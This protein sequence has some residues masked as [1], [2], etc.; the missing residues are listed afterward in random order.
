MKNSNLHICRSQRA[1][2]TVSLK[3][4][5]PI[6]PVGRGMYFGLRSSN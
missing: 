3:G 1:V 2:Y 4:F 5:D 6:E